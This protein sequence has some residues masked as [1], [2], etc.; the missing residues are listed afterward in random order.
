MEPGPHW[1]EAGAL[2]NAPP[3]LLICMRFVLFL[4]FCF[5]FFFFNCDTPYERL[6]TL[7]Q[8]RMETHKNKFPMG[9]F[10]GTGD[11]N[12]ILAANTVSFHFRFSITFVGNPEIQQLK[13][14]CVNKH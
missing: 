8:V 10:I 6:Y 5:N 12:S 9:V 3:L 1:W 13:R 7:W 14:T 11:K 2:T 4:L